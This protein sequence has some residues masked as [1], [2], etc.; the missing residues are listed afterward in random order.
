MQTLEMRSHIF[1][2]ALSFLLVSAGLAQKG[3][4]VNET[5]EF[6]LRTFGKELVGETAEGLGK[7]VAQV[8]IRYGDDGITALRKV[9]PRAFE[10]IS[11][12]GK[13]GADVVKLMAKYGDEAVWVVSKPSGMAIFIK[14]GDGAAEAMMKH[15]GIAVPFIEKTG[16]SGAKALNAVGPE[17]ARRLVNLAEDGVIVPG[18]DSAR[19]LD[20]V[21]RYGDEAA[22]FIWKNKGALAVGTVLASF[23]AN[24]EP[25]IKGVMELPN[26]AAKELVPRVNWT[27]VF[28]VGMFVTG[29]YLLISARLRRPKTRHDSA[30]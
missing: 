7:K 9:G 16:P 13:N 6:L 1:C 12:A 27:L 5:V 24:P 30:P 17:N 26:T 20:V 21:A 29:T 11:G 19:L 15:K 23:L 3:A 25:F 28:I 4:V 22:D 2:F 8:S 14:Y 10:V 18:A